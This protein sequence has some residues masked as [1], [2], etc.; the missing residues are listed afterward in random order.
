MI[1]ILMHMRIGEPHDIGSDEYNSN[2]NDDRYNTYNSDNNYNDNN[3]AY[4]DRRSRAQ[5]LL[6]RW[7]LQQWQVPAG[8]LMYMYV[9]IYI[10]TYNIYIY[11]Y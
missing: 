3:D 6:R 2:N 9:Y 11:I 5:E 1:I 7:Q 8:S 10:Y 4:A